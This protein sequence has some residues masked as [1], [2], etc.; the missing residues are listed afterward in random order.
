MSTRLK[1]WSRHP[2]V[3]G[4]SLS[5]THISNEGD[6]ATHLLR[7][8]H[9][10]H[11]PAS[12]NTQSR[13]THSRMWGFFLYS[14]AECDEAESSPL[15]PN[16]ATKLPVFVVFG[17]QRDQHILVNSSVVGMGYS[18]MAKRL[19]FYLLFYVSHPNAFT[20]T[21][22]HKHSTH[23]HTHTHTQSTTYQPNTT[24]FIT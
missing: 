13:I 8:S 2:S 18:H 22:T 14:P 9:H 10:H 23:T 5:H 7:K 11:H 15:S 6:A 19:G 21:N 4:S 16:F 24:V 3:L 12:S 17:K 20:Y 1:I